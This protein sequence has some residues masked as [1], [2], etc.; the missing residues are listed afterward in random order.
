M[1]NTVMLKVDYWLKNLLEYRAEEQFKTRNMKSA[2][3]LKKS[4]LLMCITYNVSLYTPGENELG[5][6][7]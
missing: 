2:F 4:S 5:T 7:I 1:G 3:I 6:G